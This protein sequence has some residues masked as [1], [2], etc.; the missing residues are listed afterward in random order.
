MVCHPTWL[1]IVISGRRTSISPQLFPETAFAAWRMTSS[2]VM[3]PYDIT[4]REIKRRAEI[5]V[6]VTNMN[7]NR[8]LVDSFGKLFLLF[9]V[10]NS[11]LVFFKTFDKAKTSENHKHRPHRQHKKSE[12]KRWAAPI[13][14]NTTIGVR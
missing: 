10:L 13:Y 7:T 12:N 2:A 3:Y 8:G 14:M 6:Q 1:S 9:C 5:N 11:L 4:R